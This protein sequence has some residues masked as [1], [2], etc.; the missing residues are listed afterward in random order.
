MQDTRSKTHFR[1]P[2]GSGD[3]SADTSFVDRRHSSSDGGGPRTDQRSMFDT[4]NRLQ[5]I[6][7]DEDH[8][9]GQR[10]KGDPRQTFKANQAI[11]P[12]DYRYYH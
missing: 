10:R 9:Q 1:P 8:H 4:H 6:I 3:S 5:P 12:N 7:L 11:D 2:V